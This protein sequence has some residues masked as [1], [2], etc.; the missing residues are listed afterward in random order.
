MCGWV[1]VESLEEVL[2]KVH[3]YVYGNLDYQLKLVGRGLFSAL[4]KPVGS[5]RS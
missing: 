1:D 4:G 3:I 5:E 2:N